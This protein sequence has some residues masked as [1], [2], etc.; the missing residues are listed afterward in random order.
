MSNIA[1]T[2]AP[3]W[4]RKLWYDSASIYLEMPVTDHPPII[5]KFDFTDAGLS[6]ALKMMKQVAETSA[7]YAGK[8]GWERPH[9]VVKRFTQNAKPAPQM[10]TE[11][12]SLARDILRKLRMI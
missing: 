7:E 11:S 9:P 6:K 5:L 4:A 1:P 12:R 8:N 10:T 3:P 2:G